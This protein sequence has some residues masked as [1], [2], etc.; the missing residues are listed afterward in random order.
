MNSLGIGII[1]ESPLNPGWAVNAH[2]LALKA[3]PDYELRAVSTSRRESA[4]AVSKAFGVAA[5]FDNHRDLID[6]PGVDLVVVTVTVPQ[7][8]E[9]VS[10]ALDA[11]KMVFCEWPL[12]NGLAEALDLTARAEAAGVRTAV[13]L[14]ARFASAIRHARELIVDGY[15]DFQQ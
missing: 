14:Q 5:S 7:H 9:L 2:I 12:G 6:H 3:L 8:H 11:G 1:G 10:A 13:G 4:E 15:M